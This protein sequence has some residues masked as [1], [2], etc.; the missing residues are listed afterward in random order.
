MQDDL[1]TKLLT[2]ILR[3]GVPCF[4][5]WK[6]EAAEG[7]IGKPIKFYRMIRW[8]AETFTKLM[9]RKVVRGVSEN[10]TWE[11][12]QATDR[13][14]VLCVGFWVYIMAKRLAKR[15]AR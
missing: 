1:V 8:K 9:A 13:G 11:M 12:D 2:G 14:V 10:I 5:Y 4:R 7:R 6:G 15:L 3:L